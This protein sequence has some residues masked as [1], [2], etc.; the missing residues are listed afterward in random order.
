M[1]YNEFLKHVIDDGIEAVKKDY[2]PDDNR[3]Q[4]SIAGF[5]DCQKRTI[6]ELSE[7]LEEARNSAEEKMLTCQGETKKEVDEYWYLQSRSLE[8]EWVCNTVSAVL[9][10]QALPPIVIPTVRGIMNA[11]RILGNNFLSE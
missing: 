1:N 10:N 9:V 11:A 5:E 6:G 2:K 3:Y 7:L 4:G 8:I